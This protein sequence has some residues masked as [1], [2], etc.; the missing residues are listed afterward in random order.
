MKNESVD[1]SVRR[2]LSCLKDDDRSDSE[3]A[4]ISGVSQPT[5]S[6][7]RRSV[8]RRHR[9]SEAFNKLCVMYGVPMP[10]MRKT[11]RGYNELISDAILD[12]WDGTD[13]HAH[14]LLVVIRGLKGLRK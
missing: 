10:S 13:A 2:V 14:A 3:I 7:L 8:G 6:R 12:A 4:R 9:I 1:A 5:V 11:G